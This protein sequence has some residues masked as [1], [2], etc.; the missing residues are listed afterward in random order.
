MK[1]NDDINIVSESV[2][3]K[4][5]KNENNN[6]IIEDLDD[7]NN[8][9]DNN[10]KQE[11]VIEADDGKDSEQIKGKNVVKIHNDSSEVTPPSPNLIEF[12]EKIYS[13]QK[14][15][16]KSSLLGKKRSKK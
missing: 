9:N 4:S 10:N 16:I 15:K 12:N 8:D 6:I 2:E 14:K 5:N 7:D 3:N 11:E 1:N 13:N